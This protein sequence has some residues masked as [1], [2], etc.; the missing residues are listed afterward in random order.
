[1]I[2]T[3]E[4]IETNSKVIRGFLSILGNLYEHLVS[5]LLKKKKEKNIDDR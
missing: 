1:M 5:F 3:I 4:T 2:Q